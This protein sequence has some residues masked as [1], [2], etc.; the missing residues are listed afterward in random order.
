MHSYTPFYITLAT[1][2]WL[3]I[4]EE[5]LYGLLRG[6]GLLCQRVLQIVVVV[7]VLGGLSALFSPLVVLFAAGFAYKVY[8]DLNQPLD[9]HQGDL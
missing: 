5:S 1:V 7:A 4:H 6:V 2:I 3:C 8:R 9:E